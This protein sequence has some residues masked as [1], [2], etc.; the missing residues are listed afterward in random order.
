MS[1]LSSRSFHLVTGPL[2]II[3]KQKRRVHRIVEQ[4]QKSC[5]LLHQLVGLPPGLGQ[6]PTS[7]HQP[8]PVYSPDLRLRRFHQRLP[9]ATVRQVARY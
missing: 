3:E 2:R 9:I 6:V 8:L 5:L 1:Q 4:Q 7:K